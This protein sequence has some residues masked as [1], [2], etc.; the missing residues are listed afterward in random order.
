MHKIILDTIE[1]IAFKYISF[2]YYYRPMILM[3]GL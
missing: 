2:A 3:N 1:N